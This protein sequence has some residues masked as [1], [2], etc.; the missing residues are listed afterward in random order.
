M[1]PE[2]INGL[3]ALTPDEP[4]TSRML[5]LVEQALAA[6]VRLLQYRNKPADSRLRIAQAQALLPLCRRYGT[7]FIINDDIKLCL[8]ID[9]DGVH[10]GKTDGNLARARERLS[11]GKLLG[12]SCYDRFEHAI[13]AKSL[14]AD[15]IAFGACFPSGTKP[16]AP[17]AELQLF[18]RARAELAMPAVAIGGITPDNVGLAIAVG[19]DAVAVIG[20]LWNS[21][22]IPA[23]VRQFQTSFNE[24]SLNPGH[25]DF[26]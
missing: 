20:A 15:Y 8:A 18:S 19:A 3:Y 23:T 16:G 24:H 11:P 5:A 22:D 14:G 26:T 25:H 9:A 2:R 4:D 6:G 17:R 13:A 10:L 7:T 21:A 12:A 1:T